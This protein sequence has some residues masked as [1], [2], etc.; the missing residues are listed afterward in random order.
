MI[1]RLEKAWQVMTAQTDSR[2]GKES[3]VAVGAGQWVLV[4]AH[5]WLRADTRARLAVECRSIPACSGG[6]AQCGS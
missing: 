1:A 4:L 3:A 6:K 2:P 5:W